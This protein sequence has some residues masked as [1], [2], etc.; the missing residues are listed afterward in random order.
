VEGL[1][2]GKVEV[3]PGVNLPDVCNLRLE[4]LERKALLALRC[5]LDEGIEEKCMEDG[6]V[7]IVFYGG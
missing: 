7:Y 2:E 3:K 4:M 1:C 6:G 5:E